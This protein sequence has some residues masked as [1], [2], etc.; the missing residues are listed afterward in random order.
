MIYKYFKDICK[1]EG[2][3][4]QIYMDKR[5]ETAENNILK[6]LNE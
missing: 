5:N 2:S 6:L 4:L 3:I 1:K